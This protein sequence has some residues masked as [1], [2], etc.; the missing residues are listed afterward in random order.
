[1]TPILYASTETGFTTNG[2]GRLT[3]IIECLVT[4]ERNGGYECEFKYPIS[5]IHYADIDEGCF[6]ACT[7]DDD[8]DLQPFRIYRRS[9]PLNGIVTFNARHLSYD[10]S[11]VILNPFTADSVQ[12]TLSG[13]GSNS[14]NTN[15]FTFSSDKTTL[16]PFALETPASVRSIMGGVEGSILDIYGGEWEFDKYNVYLRANRG[17]NSGVTIRYGK[18]LLDL[19]QTRDVGGLY[20]AIVPFWRQEVDG[21]DTLITLPEHMVTAAGVTN[22][23]PV[24]MDFTM[25]FQEQPTEN[26]LR[27]FAENYLTVNE[28]WVPPETLT[29][30]FVAL[31]QTLDYKDVANLLKLRLCDTV[32]VYYPA[33]GVTAHNIKVIKTVYDVLADRYYKIELGQPQA[34][35]AQVLTNNIDKSIKD[36]QAADRGFFDAAI[37]TA[38]DLLT[39]ANGGHVVIKRDANGE[40]QEILILDTDSELTATN[41][42]RIN[43]NG[44]GFSTNG[45]VSYDTAWTIDG[46]F[47]ADFITT[48]TLKAI[49]IQGPNVNTF[50]DLTSGKFQNYDEKTVTNNVNGTITTYDVQTKTVIDDGEMYVQGRKVGD[51]EDSTFIDAGILG[52]VNYTFFGEGYVPTLPGVSTDIDIKYPRGEVVLKGNKVSF[53]C[54]SGYNDGVDDLLTEYAGKGYPTASYSTD[55]IKLGTFSDYARDD[56]QSMGQAKPLRNALTLAGGWISYKDAVKFTSRYNSEVAIGTGDILKRYYDTPVTHHA[57]WDIAPYDEIYIERLYVVGCLVNSKKDIAFQIPFARPLSSDIVSVHMEGTIHARQGS[58]VLCNNTSFDSDTTSGLDYPTDLIFTPDTGLS[59]K[60]RHSGTGT[61]SSGTTY[62]PVFIT[63]TECYITA[64]DYDINDDG[65]PDE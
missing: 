13:I 56:G 41:I 7:H 26:E 50:W 33:L 5:G 43:L 19:N 4:E 65:N 35:F 49:M 38:T 47:V 10:L 34:T 58:T 60:L 3:D 42:L 20:N 31:W 9:A 25:E 28:P 54:G 14:I 52:N 64:Y 53:P 32:A 59:L 45:G 36:A 44:I 2:L 15:P 61:W 46:R 22:P 39:G 18:N 11:H 16:A 29:V 51:A 62:S 8:G 6:I 24:V 48:G 63:I 40:P 12:D 21:V 23:V 30:D 55:M 57:A 27:T 37:T 17:A 1:M